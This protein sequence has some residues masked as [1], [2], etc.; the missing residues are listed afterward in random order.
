MKKH[1]ALFCAVAAFVSFGCR[2][3]S[4]EKPSFD[5]VVDV[6]G[7]R[8]VSG[9]EVCDT[10]LDVL[11]SCSLFDNTKAWVPG[12]HAICA[13]DC[14][15]YARGTCVESVAKPDPTPDPELQCGNNE[16][17]GDELCDGNAGA[18]DCS[19]LDSTKVW[20]PGGKPECSVDCMSISRG[21]CTEMRHCGNGRLDDEELCDGALGDLSCEKYDP[22]KTWNA[23]GQATCSRDCKSLEIGT[24][25]EAP[26]CGDGMKNGT[27]ECD[28][29]DGLPLTCKD[30]NDS[31]YWRPGGKPACNESCE[32]VANTCVAYDSESVTFVNWNVLF[33]YDNHNGE[34]PSLSASVD[35]RASKL[36]EIVGKYETKPDFMSLVE[37]SPIWHSPENTEKLRQLGYEWAINEKSPGDGGREPLA[38]VVY[39]SKKYTLVETNFINLEKTDGDLVGRDK[40]IV[41]YA[42]LESKTSHVKYIVLA[43]HWDANNVWA[44]ADNN[45]PII[46][47]VGWVVNHE[48]NRVVGAKQSGE[49]VK[50]LREKYPEAR[51]IYGGDLNTVDLNILFQYQGIELANT[52]LKYYLSSQKIELDVCSLSDLPSLI[53]TINGILKKAKNDKV[54]YAPLPDDFVGSHAQLVAE[55]GLTDARSHALETGIAT[56][57]RDTWTTSDPG[58][59]E[60]IKA[61]NVPI[62]IDYAFFSSDN[63]TLT[64]YKVMTEGDEWGNTREAYMYVS[65][66]FP[67]RTTYETPLSYE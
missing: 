25:V 54:T 55:T 29:E 5:E 63:M 4:E 66:H 61:L 11:Y 2:E 51:M 40:A 47:A 60:F 50:S 18:G 35:E 58:I 37:V 23:G 13:A 33:E 42:V 62:V 41:L 3:E 53:Q 27:D 24:C 57:E 9:Q 48:Q 38:D 1:L 16:L 20:K 8:R 30:W 10:G 36:A 12:G 39:L 46:N 28:G 19:I 21:T 22:T 64:S 34:D 7:D 14:L 52:A 65:D 17:D 31:I 56:A 6:C 49:L 67:V 43:T 26:R 32:I 59:P 45:G 15:G 44:D